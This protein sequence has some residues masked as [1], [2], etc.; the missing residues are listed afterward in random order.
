M[1]ALL[2][3]FIDTVVVCSMTA[4]VIVITGN[5]GEELTNTQIN[6]LVAYLMT[7]N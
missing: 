7:L 2:E 1:V 4:L 6:D 5:Y 3:P